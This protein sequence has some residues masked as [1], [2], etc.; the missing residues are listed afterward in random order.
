MDPLPHSSLL[1]T[2]DILKTLCTECRQ[3]ISLFGRYVVASVD[4]AIS[5]LAHDLEVAAR[6]A[7]VVSS[8]TSFSRSEVYLIRIK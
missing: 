6:S 1:I 8:G 3:E 7:S 4:H 2:L 5:S